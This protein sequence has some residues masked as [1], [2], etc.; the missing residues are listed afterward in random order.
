MAI[1][2]VIKLKQNLVNPL[3]ESPKVSVPGAVIFSDTFYRNGALVGS[4]T[5]SYAGGSI[6]RWEGTAVTCQTYQEL[7]NGFLGRAE[8]SVTGIRSNCVPVNFNDFSFSFRM[9][10]IPIAGAETLAFASLID[11]RKETATSGSCYRLGFY[12]P[13]GSASNVAA[14]RLVKRIGTTGSWISED[15]PVSIGDIIRVDM[16]GDTI[17]IYVNGVGKYTFKDSAPITEGNYFGFSTSSSG[18][19]YNIEVSQLIARQL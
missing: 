11:W 17:N 4:D 10:R 15:I 18:Q 12:K 16:K 19:A 7:K 1:A 13:S 6:R 3:P 8:L 9:V 5:D 2:T 14:F